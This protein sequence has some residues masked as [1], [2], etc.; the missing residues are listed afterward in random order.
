[1]VCPDWSITGGVSQ[2]C[3][4]LCSELRL[5]GHAVRVVAAGDQPVQE[6]GFEVY[7]VP[8]L[9][10]LL[11]RNPITYRLWHHIREHVD[12]CD[13]IVLFSYMFEMNSRVV[14]LRQKGKFHKPI[15][16][17]YVGSLEDHVLPHLSLPTRIG[18]IVYDRTLGKRL[19]TAVDRIIANADIGPEL[20][21]RDFRTPPEGLVVVRGAI[22][23]ADYPHESQEKE[24]V[25]FVGRLVENK[26]VNFFPQIV[27]A[28]PHY[29]SFVIVG[30]GPDRKKVAA[31]AARFGN[32]KVLGA[33]THQETKRVIASSA[34]LVLPT[35]AEGSPR[36]VME[37]AASGIPSIAF[38]VGDIR[39]MVPADCGF[40]IEPFD[41]DDFCRR[42][43]QLVNDSSERRAMG[44]NARALV[45]AKFDWTVVYPPI[46]QALREEHHRGVHRLW[47][48]RI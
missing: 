41:I 48:R 46:E 44:R 2:T 29:W 45:A 38:A 39:N 4:E 40:A 7:P 43:R 35:L 8:T 24:Q 19:F 32:L 22:H 30:E 5:H 34:V 17:F 6:R 14:R 28:I 20:K 31:L 16:Q 11:G 27:R 37:A 1:M 47:K 25:V 42:L 12:W 15:I 23:V 33:L 21:R 10:R 36:V 26:G 13:V 9:T 3:F 18:K